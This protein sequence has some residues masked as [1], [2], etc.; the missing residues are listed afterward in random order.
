MLEM[1]MFIIVF[2]LFFVILLSHLAML[3]GCKPGSGLYKVSYYIICKSNLENVFCCL[4]AVPLILG[5]IA[6]VLHGECPPHADFWASMLCN[7]AAESN[8]LPQDIVML[9]FLQPVAV[10][11]LFKGVQKE[12][13]AFTL[14]LA[15]ATTLGC[16]AYLGAWNQIWAW[17]IPTIK[18]AMISYELER[19]KVESFL[20]SRRAL[21]EERAKRHQA[22]EERR[23]Q[24]RLRANLEAEEALLRAKRRAALLVLPV[25]SA[26]VAHAEARAALIRRAIVP[27][28]SQLGASESQLLS[29]P[30]PADAAP[31]DASQ[32]PFG[33]AKPDGPP[34]EAEADVAVVLAAVEGHGDTLGHRDFDGRTAL[35]LALALEGVVPSLLLPI[36]ARSL[37]FDPSAA[38]APVPAAAHGFAWHAA[39]QEDRCAAAV[40]GVLAAWPGLAEAL[41]ASADAQG[42]PAVNVASPLCRAAL[43]DSL[44]LL[45]RYEIR[46]LARPHHE[47]ATCVVHLGVDHGDSEG[48]RPVALKFMRLRGQFLRELDAR[49]EGGFGA[50]FVV[51]ALRG[52]DGATDPE[53]LAEARRKG[54]GDTPFCVVMEAGSR[55]L[56]DIVVKERLA[57]DWDRIRALSTQVAC[58]PAHLTERAMARS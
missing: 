9:L 6:R 55:S 7:T 46:T 12:V 8:T 48:G 26:L 30:A 40:E 49:R 53:F 13:I 33:G 51:G 11:V 19:S 35:E 16:I 3:L 41:A 28:A 42:R 32:R 52:H 24:E 14:L 18:S 58:R 25:H 23:E 29:C 47:S 39:V 50:E 56:A 20:Q 15:S 36:L 44:R 2:V 34:G 22:E 4:V 57:G 54:L 38:A 17:A 27:P 1:G 10:L 43:L 37:P 31:A 21:S 5:L 45:R